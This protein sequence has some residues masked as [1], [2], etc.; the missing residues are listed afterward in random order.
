MQRYYDCFHGQPNP[1]TF[2]TGII[3]VSIFYTWVHN[4]THR[5]LLSAF[6][7]HFSQNFAGQIFDLTGVA[8]NIQGFRRLCGSRRTT[9]ESEGAEETWQTAPRLAV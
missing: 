8:N 5:S 2:A 6:V 4:N 3:V 7:F 9:L 1:F